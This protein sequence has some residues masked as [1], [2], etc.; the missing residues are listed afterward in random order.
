MNEDKAQRLTASTVTGLFVN[1]SWSEKVSQKFFFETNSPFLTS[2][3]KQPKPD[4]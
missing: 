1:K 2:G 4:P 3:D